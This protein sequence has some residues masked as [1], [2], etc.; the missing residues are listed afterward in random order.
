MQYLL[1]GGKAGAKF[2]I[3]AT[4]DARR[5]LEGYIRGCIGAEKKHLRGGD[6]ITH[7]ALNF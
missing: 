1:V 3:A 5:T 6:V 2:N 4:D 7:L